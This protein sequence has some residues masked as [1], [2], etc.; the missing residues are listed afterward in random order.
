MRELA[1]AGIF[2]RTFSDAAA[3]L[4]AFTGLFGGAAHYSAI[5][6]RRDKDE[7]ERTTAFGFFLGFGLGA[8]VLLVDVLT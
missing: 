6:A 1:F 8:I 4:I 2:T 7:V 3:A 5:L